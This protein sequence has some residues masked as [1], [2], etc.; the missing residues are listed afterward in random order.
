M[1]TNQRGVVRSSRFLRARKFDVEGAF[2]QFTNTENWRRE[3]QID[4]LYAEFDV[5]EL[6]HARSVYP[7]WTGRRTRAGLPLYEFKV[8][9]LTKDVVNEYS[10][11]GQERLDLRMA[12]LSEV[13]GSAASAIAQ[14]GTVE[15]S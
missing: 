13:S 14:L 8:G 7:Q 10:K 11:V 2:Q 12:A 6:D 3:K 4:K 5:N 15:R 1:L 9:T